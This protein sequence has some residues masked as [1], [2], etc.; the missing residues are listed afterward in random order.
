MPVRRKVLIARINLAQWD[1]Q[2]SAQGAVPVAELHVDG[3]AVRPVDRGGCDVESTVTIEVTGRDE[4]GVE[5][6]Q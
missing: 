2:G 4:S 5:Q 1:G 6:L 3:K